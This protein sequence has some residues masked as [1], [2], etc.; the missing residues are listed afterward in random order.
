MTK[1]VWLLGT[2]ILPREARHFLFILPTYINFIYH[3]HTMV[4]KKD[5]KT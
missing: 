4:K 3:A 2:I 1:T 5:K